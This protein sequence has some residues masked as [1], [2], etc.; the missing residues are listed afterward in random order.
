VV[1]QYLS[2]DMSGKDQGGSTQ[3]PSHGLTPTIDY[4]E[5]GMNG[6]HAPN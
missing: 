1:E 2:A 6:V 4:S 5:G 3:G